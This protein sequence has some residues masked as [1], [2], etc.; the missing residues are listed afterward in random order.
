MQEEKQLMGKL[1]LASPPPATQPSVRDIECLNECA[2]GKVP[3]T[4]GDMMY[5][6]LKAKEKHEN[7]SLW[8]GGEGKVDGSC[9]NIKQ[10][11]YDMYK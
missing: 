2:H 9:S 10:T 3:L 8:E 11:W 6:I 5:N 1:Q 7:C 4:S